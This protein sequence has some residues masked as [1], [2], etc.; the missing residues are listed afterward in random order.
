MTSHELA[1]IL[2]LNKDMPVVTHANNHTC[3]DDEK[4]IKVGIL[5]LY[6]KEEKIVIGNM[7]K[8]N[9]NK[10]NW[11]ITKMLTEDIPEEW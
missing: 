7:S 11:Y 4:Y 3:A 9:L 6:S 1:K 5:K 2:L 8:K 10:P